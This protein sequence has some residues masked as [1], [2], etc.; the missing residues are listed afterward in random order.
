M[1]P[2]GIPIIENNDS[3][4]DEAWILFKRDAL[5]ISQSLGGKLPVPCVL[6][7]SGDQAKH[8]L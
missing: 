3:S 7:G 1:E 5:Q 8:T 2:F 6:T 4:P